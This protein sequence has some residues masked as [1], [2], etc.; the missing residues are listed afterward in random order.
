MSGQERFPRMN[1]PVL[2]REKRRISTGMANAITARIADSPADFRLI[3]NDAGAGAQRMV[4][5]MT[6]LSFE[7]MIRAPARYV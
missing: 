5:V 6:A 3:R 1:I 7:I 2:V 4:R